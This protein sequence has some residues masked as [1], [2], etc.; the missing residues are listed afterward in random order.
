MFDIAWPASVGFCFCNSPWH[1]TRLRSKGGGQQQ[2]KTNETK[3]IK[4]HTKQRSKRN[5]KKSKIK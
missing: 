4:R 3:Q 5:N 2:Q 1:A